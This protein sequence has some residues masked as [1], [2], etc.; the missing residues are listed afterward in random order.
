VRPAVRC[1]DLACS[2]IRV[3]PSTSTLYKRKPWI[4]ATDC[5]NPWSS[6]WMS[7]RALVSVPTVMRA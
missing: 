7:I 3:P 2:L 4:N 5:P 1:H 6:Y